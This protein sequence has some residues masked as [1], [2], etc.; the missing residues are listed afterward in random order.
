MRNYKYQ[1]MN[2][3]TIAEIETLMVGEH[4]DA[5]WAFGAEC[6]NYYKVMCDRQATVA[7]VVGVL[8]AGA[9]I[10]GKK[11]IQKHKEEKVKE[12]WDKPGRDWEV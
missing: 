11:V 9:V 6:M 8:A 3:N 1:Y 7:A 2:E 10:V 12:P 4:K 5:V